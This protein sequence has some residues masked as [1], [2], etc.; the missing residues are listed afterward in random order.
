MKK[1]KFSANKL[2]NII[3]RLFAFAGFVASVLIF[4]YEDNKII[5]PAQWMNFGVPF[6]LI[7]ISFVILFLFRTPKNKK[8]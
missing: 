3:P 6:L 1:I 5:F 8:I 4:A 2:W 7:I